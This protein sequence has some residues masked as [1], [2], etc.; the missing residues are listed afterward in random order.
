MNYH[1]DRTRVTNS[2]LKLFARA[3]LLWKL[4]RDGN[5][6]YKRTPDLVFGSLVHCLALEPHRLADLFAVEP[7][8]APKKP[9]KAQIQAWE[10]FGN[11]AKPTRQQVEAHDRTVEAMRFWAKWSKASAGKYTIDDADL[12]RARACLTGLH[13][14]PKCREWLALPGLSE[15]VVQWTDPDTGLPCKAKLDRVTRAAI[16]DL[17]TAADASADAFRRAAVTNGYHRQAAWYLDGLAAAL[18]QGTLHPE[19]ADLI[20]GQ[21]PGLFV[22]PAVEKDDE[23]LAHCFVATEAFIDRGRR[24]N[25][26]LMA[27]L[28][29]CLDTDTWPGLATSE[30]G[31]T[32]L[33]LPGWMPDIS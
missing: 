27:R 23:F 26:A 8:D 22:F 14:N 29:H 33:D 9:T 25:K 2:S 4:W 28:K 6:I 1:D 3:P 7:E 30:N 32:A 24:E 5:L 19:V 16:L 21:P 15:V 18:A 31:M 10:R 12:T 11:L 20:Q 13:A 17:K